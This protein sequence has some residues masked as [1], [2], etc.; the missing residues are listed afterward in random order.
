M[1]GRVQIGKEIW[2]IVEVY[3]KREEL[4]KILDL[5]DR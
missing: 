5:L 2:R 1:L 3:V 4:Y